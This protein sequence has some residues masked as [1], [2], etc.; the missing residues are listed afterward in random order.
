MKTIISLA[1]ILLSA[2]IVHYIEDVKNIREPSIY[3]IIGVTT[4][5]LASSVGILLNL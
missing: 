5:L 2:G 1:I 3:W 4:G